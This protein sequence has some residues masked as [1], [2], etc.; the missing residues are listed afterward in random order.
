MEKDKK[1]AFALI[2]FFVLI[3]SVFG[4]ALYLKFGKPNNTNDF[5]FHYS[6]II[7]ENQKPYAPLYHLL[8]KPFQNPLAFYLA[9]VLLVMAAIPFF[10]FKATKTFWALLVYF[11]GIA[12]SWQT[13]Y[14]ALYPMALTFLYFVIYLNWRKNIILLLALTL[15]AWKTH[16]FGLYFFLLVWLA[17]IVSHSGK[18]MLLLLALGFE[19]FK[20][21]QAETGQ[22]IAEKLKTPFQWGTVFLTL[23]PVPTA[24]FAWKQLTTKFSAFFFILIFFAFWFALNEMRA[25]AVVEICSV[26]LVTE[27]IKNSSRKL[28]IGFACFFVAQTLYYF[29]EYWHATIKFFS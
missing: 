11:C 3:Y 22:L 10:I 16:S 5:E 20:A 13:M 15:L 8:F 7:G 26:F 28:K 14:A 24:F 19:N 23:L 1:R 27:Q 17:E 9:N 29:M 12:F 6:K 18:R 21:T 2:V 25:L 4:T